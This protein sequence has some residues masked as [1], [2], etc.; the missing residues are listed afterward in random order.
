MSRSIYTMIV[1]FLLN[2]QYITWIIE[3]LIVSCFFS[4]NLNLNVTET[5]ENN[6]PNLFLEWCNATI[7][8]FL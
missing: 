6:V 2:F 7:D 4:G 3:F 1:K 8:V 5:Y